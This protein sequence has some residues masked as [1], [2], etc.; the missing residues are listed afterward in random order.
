MIALSHFPLWESL[1]W[2]HAHDPS[3][4]LVPLPAGHSVAASK[5]VADAL[6]F[7]RQGS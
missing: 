2:R 7:C 5:G 6:A 1:T 4:A 3:A